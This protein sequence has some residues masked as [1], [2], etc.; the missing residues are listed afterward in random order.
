MSKIKE[1]V[2]QILSGQFKEASATLKTVVKQRVS[3]KFKNQLKQENLRLPVERHYEVVSDN[4]GLYEV[5]Q[6]LPLSEYGELLKHGWQTSQVVSGQVGLSK[7]SNGTKFKIQ[8]R[9]R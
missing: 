8:L 3:D 4:T 7:T 2:N 5:G 6:E 9:I 1:Y